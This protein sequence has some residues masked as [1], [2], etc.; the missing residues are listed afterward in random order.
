MI[1]ALS[2]E[3]RLI[4]ALKGCRDFSDLETAGFLF[5]GTCERIDGPLR[6]GAYDGVFWA[7]RTPAIAQAYIPRAG[8]SQIISRPPD[9]LLEDPIRPRS[10]DD[11]VTAWA[12]SRAQARWDDLEVEEERG[13]ICSWRCLPG[14][15]SNGELVRHIEDDLGY[16]PESYGGW[17]VSTDRSGGLWEMRPASWSLPG[18]LILLH[19][20]DLKISSADWRESEIQSA[21]HNRLEAFARLEREGCEAFAM[22]DLLQSKHHGNLGH[23][24]IGILPRALERLEWISIP[25]IRHDGPDPDI[26]QRKETPDFLRY[27]KQASSVYAEQ[28]QPCENIASFSP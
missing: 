5:H 2:P 16:E 19:A 23:E 28:P 7:A 12:L 18:S 26:F 10:P 20:P 4:A 27:M 3:S 14:W 11:L 1:S 17:E 25:A 15:P 6:P 24:A 21:N 13:R 22:Q 9:S 8:I